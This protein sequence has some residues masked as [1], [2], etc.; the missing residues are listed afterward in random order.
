ME[1]AGLRWLAVPG[2]VAVAEPLD[3]SPTHLSTT[4]LQSAAPT[5]AAA[6]EFGRRLAA[7][8]DAGARYFGV[9]LR[10]GEACVANIEMPFTH[11]DPP[12]TT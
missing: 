11:S 9:V 12:L 3:V 4:R 1:A 8:H 7:T 2:G 6:D 10:C 5:G